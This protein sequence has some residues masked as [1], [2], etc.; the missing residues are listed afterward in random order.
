MELVRCQLWD[1]VG[2]IAE[3]STAR[4]TFSRTGLPPSMG[5][6]DLSDNSDSEAEDEAD[7][8]SNGSCRE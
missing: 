8:D 7:E 4:L 3:V 2:R 1:G 6:E 5:D